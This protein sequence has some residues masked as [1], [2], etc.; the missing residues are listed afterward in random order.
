[1]L[2]KLLNELIVKKLTEIVKRIDREKAT[3]L[4]WG[5]DTVGWAIYLFQNPD[6]S[7]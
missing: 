2:P 4:Q 1:M 7:R 5:R 6:A 3:Y